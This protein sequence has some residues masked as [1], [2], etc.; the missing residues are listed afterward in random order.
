MDIYTENNEQA[1]F[2]DVLSDIICQYLEAEQSEHI[3]TPNTDDVVDQKI[4]EA[5]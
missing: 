2:I 5:A 4:T 3:E 1:L